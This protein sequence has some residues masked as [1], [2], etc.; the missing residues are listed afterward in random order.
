MK[1]PSPPKRTCGVVVAR[2][3]CDRHV[4]LKPTHA[5][6]SASDTLFSAQLSVQQSLGQGPQQIIGGL[7]EKKD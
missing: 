2:P 5:T 1:Q 6:A 7:D 4:N 3:L